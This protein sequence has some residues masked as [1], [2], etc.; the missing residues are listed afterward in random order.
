MLDENGQWGTVCAQDWDIEDTRVA[1]R[2]LER[3]GAELDD[4]ESF[5]A[6][7]GS[8][9]IVTGGLQCEGDENRL[10]NCTQAADWTPE[11]CDP[12]LHG[13]DIG[14]SCDPGEIRYVKI[15]TLYHDIHLL[16]H[17]SDI[18]YISVKLRK[19]SADE[20]FKYLNYILRKNLT[21]S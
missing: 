8:G 13:Q 3:T 16:P 12:S 5:T 20:L 17:F 4:L 7:P 14:V 18:L 10:D 6:A 1:C 2:Q 15:T 11:S 19:K 21:R 9:P